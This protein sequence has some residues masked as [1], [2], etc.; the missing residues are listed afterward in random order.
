MRVSKWVVAGITAA[1]LV[2]GVCRSADAAFVGM[3]GMSGQMAKRISF[4][5][6]TLPP[7]AFTQF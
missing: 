3:P 6:Y 2:A 1:I 4:G 7:M 5:N